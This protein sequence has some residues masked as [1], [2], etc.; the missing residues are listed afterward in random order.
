MI[1]GIHIY[2]CFLSSGDTSDF[3]VCGFFPP[4]N[5]VIVYSEYGKIFINKIDF[6]YQLKPVSRTCIV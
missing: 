4:W 5:A 6:I 3:T 1:M 2:I